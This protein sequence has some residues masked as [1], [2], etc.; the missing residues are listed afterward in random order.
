[1]NQTKAKGAVPPST[2]SSAVDANVPRRPWSKPQM[3]LLDYT[4]TETTAKGVG[5]SES[6]R[7]G[8]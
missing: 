6:T 2:E 7:Y 8:S 5:E 3:W 1:M 4:E